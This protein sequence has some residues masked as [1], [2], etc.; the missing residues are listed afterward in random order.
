[1]FF[2]PLNMDIEKDIRC[3]I[4]CRVSSKEQEERGYSLEAQETLLTGYSDRR[5]FS[6]VR[7]F[8]ISESASGKQIRKIFNEMITFVKKEKIN[9]ILCEKIDRLTRNLK[10][11]AMISDWVCGNEWRE[12][13][14]VKEN[15]IVS[16]NTKA[17]ENLVWDMKVAIARFYTNNLSEEVKKGQKAKIATGWIP[18]GLKF[19]YRTIGEQGHK[20]QVPDEKIAPFIKRSFEL[21]NSGN[22]TIKRL[23]ETMAQEG[24]R[25]RSGKEIG[26]SSFHH[27]M[28]DPFYCGR[29]T[30]NGQEYQGKHEPIIT[31]ELFD[32]VQDKLQRTYKAGQL[33]KH[34]HTFKGMI[35]CADCGCAIT[36]ETQKGHNYGRCKG[37]KNCPS[38]VCIKEEKVEEKLDELMGTIK[39][40]SELVL[41]WITKALKEKNKDKIDYSATT[42]ETLT[43]A[44]K[45]MENRLD[46]IYEDKLDGVISGE[47]Y[48]T[49][50]NEYTKKKKDIV[51]DIG[52][53]E[54]RVDNYY[55]IGVEI[56]ELAFNAL[57]L[58]HDRGA[59]FDDKRT[60]V[61]RIFTNM[62]LKKDKELV[63]SY[64]PA[65]KFLSEWI[66]KLNATSELLKQGEYYRKTGS[67]EPAHPMLLR[68]WDSN[69]RPIG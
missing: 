24:F 45:Q 28:S 43:A 12:V 57:K 60:L 35:K 38:K 51:K 69:P 5:E 67:L 18:N 31:E 2:K 53:L 49:K 1:M 44:L 65:Y 54:S 36:W 48:Q 41:N 6:V 37:F 32:E 20:T 55:Q 29:I 66:P 62:S 39:P 15:F 11:A 30:W 9:V 46:K 14:F 40:T 58:Y 56:H 52:S 7:I 33:K 16:R 10:D 61:S 8:K 25:N 17:H 64:A 22:Y 42:R 63:A 21:Y 68:G 27:F 50:F 19:G 23:V 47:Y 4:L 3:I 13:H 26:K 59:T 34:F